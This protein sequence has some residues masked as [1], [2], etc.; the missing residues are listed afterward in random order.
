MLISNLF[1]CRISTTRQ[2]HELKVS[3]H[4]CVCNFN[5]KKIVHTKFV[6]ANYCCQL[7][8]YL[9]SLCSCYVLILHSAKSFFVR[10]CIFFKD[11]S[12]CK[13][14]RSYIQWCYFCSHLRSLTAAMLVFL[15]VENYKK[16]RLSHSGMMF[17]PRFL[18]I[19][20]VVRSY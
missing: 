2:G 11:L 18:K 9:W 13:V 17:I 8:S 20:P 5:V 14:S 1:L 4:L 6:G 10:S 12:P 16:L 3:H 19:Y 7:E 15:I